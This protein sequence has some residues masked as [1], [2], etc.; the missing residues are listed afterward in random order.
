MEAATFLPQAKGEQDSD[1]AVVSH[2]TMGPWA[3]K[4][5][6]DKYAWK[7]RTENPRRSGQTPRTGSSDTFWGLWDTQTMI[8]SFRSLLN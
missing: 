1:S 7:D 8:G 6:I 2:D 3:E 5:Y 4:I